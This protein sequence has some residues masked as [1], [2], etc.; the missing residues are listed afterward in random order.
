MEMPLVSVI[1]PVY[2]SEHSLTDCVD[3]LLGQTYKRLE[4]L[5]VNDGSTD[6]S[7][8]ICRD[9]ERQD[10]RVVYICQ[11]NRGVSAAR[12]EGLRRASGQPP[13]HEIFL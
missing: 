13:S 12:N 1:V 8:G 2:N 6:R 7:A 10:P 9:Y 4:I 11:R 3:A 5:L